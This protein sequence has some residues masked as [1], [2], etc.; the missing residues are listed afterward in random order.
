MKSL[1]IAALVLVGSAGSLGAQDTLSA[2]REL[3]AT[4][5]YE[6]AL[7]TLS[8]IDVAGSPDLARQ[9]DDYRAFSLFALGRTREAESMAESVIRRNPLA[10]L[11][12]ADTSPR[13]ERLFSDVRTRLLPSLIRDEFRAARVE[14]E[15]KTFSAAEAPLDHARQMIAEA[16]RL[17]VKDDGLS[18][19]TV[20]VDGFLQLIRS[21]AEERATPRAEAA[22]ASGATQPAL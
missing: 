22:A 2:A 20:L 12:A 4:A 14:I 9:V 3:Y 17:G 15:R 11:D 7:S 10:Q 18:D 13:L 5:A 8:R 6:D 16:Q 1:L 21:T 19:L